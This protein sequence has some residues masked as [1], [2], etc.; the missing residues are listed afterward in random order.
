MEHVTIYDSLRET[1]DKINLKDAHVNQISRL[2][3]V[4][5]L[6][7]DHVET[8]EAQLEASQ[9]TEQ[10]HPVEHVHPHIPEYSGPRMCQVDTS[11]VPTGDVYRREQI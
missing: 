7:C 9:H 3:T 4:L 8:L 2:I 1:L 6:L 5:S 11:P 10:T